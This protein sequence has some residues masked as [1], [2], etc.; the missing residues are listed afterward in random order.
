MLLHDNRYSQDSYYIFMCSIGELFRECPPSLHWQIC[1]W[2]GFLAFQG[3]AP[4]VKYHFFVVNY[5]HGGRLQVL[6]FDSGASDSSHL[7]IEAAHVSRLDS[8]RRMI[9][10]GRRNKELRMVKFVELGQEWKT[11]V[12]VCVRNTM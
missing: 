7:R 10:E 11:D 4:P 3:Q 5:G 6:A 8:W 2:E 9:S 1:A 12:E